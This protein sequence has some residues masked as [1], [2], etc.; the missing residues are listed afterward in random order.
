MNYLLTAG[1]YSDYE[2]IGMVRHDMKPSEDKELLARYLSA[3]GISQ[4]FFNA[5]Y[6]R[7][8]NL[9]WS[10]SDFDGCRSESYFCG[11]GFLRWV[12]NESGLEN[13]EYEEHSL[14]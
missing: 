5:F 13:I 2:V 1:S 14:D 10:Y 11:G 9:G 3:E 6:N 4:E 12:L 8:N 7:L